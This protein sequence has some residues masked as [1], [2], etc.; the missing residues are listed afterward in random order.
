MASLMRSISSSRENVPVCDSQRELAHL[1]RKKPLSLSRQRHQTALPWKNPI[2][3]NN[4]SSLTREASL[5][6]RLSPTSRSSGLGQKFLIN[7]LSSSLPLILAFR[8][9]SMASCPAD[10]HGPTIEQMASN[11]VQCKAPARRSQRNGAT[12]GSKKE[13]TLTNSPGNFL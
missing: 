2:S 13:S 5:A 3:P 7:P 12:D 8:L 11:F 1:Q 6:E 10:A 4:S 9:L